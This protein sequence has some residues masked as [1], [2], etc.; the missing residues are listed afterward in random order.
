[1]EEKWTDGRPC[2]WGKTLC[3]KKY[4]GDGEDGAKRK[5]MQ[6][7]MVDG[8]TKQCNIDVAMTSEAGAWRF[9]AVQHLTLHAC[10]KAHTRFARRDP[11][12]YDGAP[13]SFAMR[14]SSS[15]PF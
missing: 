10:T 9:V 5:G 4:A 1:M 13:T 6:E 7:N 14:F 8:T 12:F 15:L 2:N 11:R 3:T